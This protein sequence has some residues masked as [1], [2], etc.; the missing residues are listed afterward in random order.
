M[1]RF[2][3]LTMFAFAC[4]GS[5]GSD[6]VDGGSQPDGSNHSTLDPAKCAAFAQ[7]AVDAA[8]TCGSP[9]PQ[10]AAAQLET[11]CR[12]GVAAASSCGGNP[13]GGLDCFAS[14]DPTDWV[15]E[16]GQPYP[17][18]NG[19][20]AAGL[21]AYCLIS[22]GNPSCASGVQCQFDVDCSGNALCNSVTHQ[23]VQKSAYCVGL[24]CEFDVDCPSAEKCNSAEHACV[25]Q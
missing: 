18:C 17:S 23:C 5:G 21:G 20:L 12:K 2:Y 6:S 4:G 1:T 7:S 19:D 9:L 8:A 22:L 13:S 15:C 16:L 3:W 11:M 24:P 10:G 14:P 25:G